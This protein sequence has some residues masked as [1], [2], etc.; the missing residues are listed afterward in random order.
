MYT[1]VSFSVVPCIAVNTE[2]AAMTDPNIQTKAIIVSWYFGTAF[3]ILKIIMN[4]LKIRQIILSRT[5]MNRFWRDVHEP[6]CIRF[7]YLTR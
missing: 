7:F 2:N 6:N 4:K 5:W 1:V 3:Q